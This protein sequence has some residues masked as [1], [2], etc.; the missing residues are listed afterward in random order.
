MFIL[1]F[2]SLAQFLLDITVIEHSQP[3]NLA[4]RRKICVIRDVRLL[5]KQVQ[6][7][8]SSY[9]S[10]KVRKGTYFEQFFKSLLL[11]QC[12]SVRR[13]FQK[14]QRMF[15]ELKHK[16]FKYQ[17]DLQEGVFYNR[18]LFEKCL[19]VKRHFKWGSCVYRLLYF[20]RS[21]GL[22]LQSTPHSDSTAILSNIFIHS[23]FD[24]NI[25][26]SQMPHELRNERGNHS[27]KET[28]WNFLTCFGTVIQ[29]TGTYP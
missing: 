4:K 19:G 9:T 2:R 8:H 18:P 27:E 5:A 14:D 29:S 7:H 10:C 6:I 21:K 16:T 28:K 15:L 25:A 12:S 20:V 17:L 22:L 24:L 11:F 3:N 23:C 13:D 26:F 1:T